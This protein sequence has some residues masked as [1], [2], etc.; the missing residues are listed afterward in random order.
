MESPARYARTLCIGS[1]HVITDADVEVGGWIKGFSRVTHLEVDSEMYFAPTI[2]LVPLHGFSPFIKSLRVQF[3][4]LPSSRIIG[5]ALSFP[6]LEDLTAGI[7]FETWAN[8][9]GGSGELPAFAH[10]PSLP[11]FTGSLEL[12][13]AGMGPIA[14][15]LL[16]LQGDIYFR[17]LI[18]TWFY[19]ED[20]LLATGL[21]E[22]RSHTLDSIEF[23]CGTSTRHRNPRRLL[24]PVFRDAGADFDRPLKGDET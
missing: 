23:F 14:R 13:K 16:S 21:V 8:R 11:A 12:M 19:K 15:Q 20:T 17:E 2:S 3:A 10:P 5:L 7:H 4:G 22:R 9:S 24:T 1:P 18:L 6:L